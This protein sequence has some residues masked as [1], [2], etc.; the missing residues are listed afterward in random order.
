MHEAP[1]SRQNRIVNQLMGEHYIEIAFNVASSISFVA[2]SYIVYNGWR[3]F[4]KKDAYPEPISGVAGYKYVLKFYAPQHRMEQRLMKWLA[5]PNKEVTFKLTTTLDTFAQLLVDNMNANDA[6]EAVEFRWT[7]TPSLRNDTR[8]VI[9]DG[10]SCWE[11][12]VRIAEAFGAE[13]W[14][15]DI[16]K[17]Q[18]TNELQLN[19]GKLAIGSNWEEIREGEVV[20]FLPA[21]KRG[22]DANYGT[23]YYIYGSTKNIPENYYESVEGGVT[24]HISEKRLHLPDG[25]PYIDVLNGEVVNTLPA[26][27]VIE[28]VIFLDDVF[29]KNTS[30]I[31][32]IEE[33]EEEII[34]GRQ[35]KSYTIVAI[36]TGFDG[37]DDNVLGTLGVTFTSGAL[38]GSSFDVR[39]NKPF[40]NRFHITPRVEG[41]TGSDQIVIPNYNI[42]P[43]VGDTFVLTGIKLPDENILKAENELLSTGKAKAKEYG[44][45][46]NVYEC[47]TDPVYCQN[48]NK[49][50]RLGTRVKLL[51][52]AFGEEGRLSRIQGYEKS[53]YNE[54]DAT[55][56]VGDNAIYSRI[57]AIAKGYANDS[58]RVVREEST[59]WQNKMNVTI[60]SA[61]GNADIANKVNVLI[62]NDKDMSAR[63]IAEEVAN[64]IDERVNILIGNDANKSVRTIANEVLAGAST[65][66][67]IDLDLYLSKSEAEATYAT[68]ESLETANDSIDSIATRLGK[69]ETNIGNNSNLLSAHSQQLQTLQTNQEKQTATIQQQ[70]TAI[71]ALDAEVD[72]V[73]GDVS[74]AKGAIDAIEVELENKADKSVVDS[75]SKDLVSTKEVVEIISPQVK[76]NADAIKG[77]ASQEAVDDISESVTTLEGSVEEIS[78]RVNDKADKE[79]VQILAS[80]INTKVGKTD[81]KSLTY[82]VNGVSQTFNGLT[83]ATIPQIFTPTQTGSQGQVLQSMGGGAPQWANLSDIKGAV[84]FAKDLTGVLEATPEEFTF[85]PSAGDKSIRDESAVIRRIKGNTIVSGN[86]MHSMKAV[87]IET[88]GFNQWDEEWENGS[89]DITTGEN[90]VST[91]IRCKNLIRVLPNTY[92]SLSIG[93]IYMGIWAM[94]YDENNNILSPV[95]INSF[96]AG[97][98]LY[99][100]PADNRN[101]F[102]TPA[103]A[104]WMKFYLPAEY[105]TSYNN[106]ICI[107][108]SHSGVRN[109]ECHPYKRSIFELPEVLNYFPEGMN[110]VGEVYDEI[111]S[112]N[113]IQRCGIR[114]YTNGDENNDDVRTDKKNTVYILAEPIVRPVLEPIQL[115]YDVEDFGTERVISREGSSPFRADIVYQF[116]A[117]GRIR[118]NGRNIERIEAQMKNLATREYVIEVMPT[119]V[120]EATQLRPFTSWDN[121]KVLLPNIMYEFASGLGENATVTLPPLAQQEGAYDHVWMLRLPSIANSNS[122]QYTYAIKWKDGTPPTFVTAC[123]LEIYLKTDGAGAILGEWKIY[124]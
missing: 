50:Y 17:V 86:E 73:K 112:E 83:E 60:Q 91:Q 43:A 82:T 57:A 27:R 8:E 103:N 5:S 20:T 95:N 74:E 79:Q 19:F 117:E 34:E 26:S 13:Y 29:P 105:G 111:N 46:T 22:V 10:V 84:G 7:Y 12:M 25:M 63:E 23:R 99:V 40:D 106:D 3:Y 81:L 114:R 122:L 97:K 68:K 121:V 52:G 119:E 44:A 37:S 66:G 18:G 6:G 45:D 118:D 120:A 30:T 80:Q 32:G 88:I 28:R 102:V 70:G 39:W 94:F 87:R 65:D 2:G 56:S 15:T 11:A 33:R 90:I 109:G 21:S 48:N 100:S 71:L 75:L 16:S 59:K 54:Y 85:R 1:M 110:S 14:L 42:N 96:V 51:G 38:S 67:D 49:N 98:C 92:Y 58:G 115:A 55:Y 62:G 31:T 108:L 36:D 104:A 69:A 53:L 4:L 101:I 24:N 113:A 61:A 124:R 93:N 41:S 76:A 107:N 89:F 64:P 35:D 78:N 123:T 9:F 116:N 77:K 47:K 72:G